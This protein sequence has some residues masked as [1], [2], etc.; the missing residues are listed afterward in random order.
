MVQMSSQVSG[1]IGVLVVVIIGAAL[2]PTLLAF[3]TSAQGN[4][5]DAGQSSLLGLVTLFYI[6]L[7]VAVPI[8]AVIAA[9]AFKK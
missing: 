4:V 5:T 3:I 6:L 1:I 2:L 7:I 8:V 9:F